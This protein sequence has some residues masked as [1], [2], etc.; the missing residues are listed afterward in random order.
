MHLILPL[1]II[2]LLGI[3]LV[4]LFLLFFPYFIFETIKFEKAKK[5]VGLRSPFKFDSYTQHGVNQFVEECR[6]KSI[7]VET[8]HRTPNLCHFIRLL[9]EKGLHLELVKDG[10]EEYN[11][12]LGFEEWIEKWRRIIFS[13]T[14]TSADFCKCIKLIMKAHHFTEFSNATQP[15]DG[16]PSGKIKEDD[17]FFIFRALYIMHYNIRIKKNNKN[18][19]V[20][21]DAASLCERSNESKLVDNSEE[22][23]YKILKLSDIVNIHQGIDISE[24]DISFNEKDTGIV[25][26][27]DIYKNRCEHYC[28]SRS[29][30][31]SSCMVN[32]GDLIMGVSNPYHIAKWRGKDS[33]L[34][35][36]CLSFHITDE[37]VNSD[38]LLLYLRLVLEEIKTEKVLKEKLNFDEIINILIVIPPYRMQRKIINESRDLKNDF[39]QIKIML[40]NLDKQFIDTINKNVLLIS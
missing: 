38:F 34:A 36:K 11:T 25:Y 32:L 26:M 16:I 9:D 5:K 21:F 3:L 22:Q 10:H 23:K 2:V 18:V 14:I 30:F 17:S 24:K 33:I 1:L 39:E 8:S 29:S 27:N 28:S 31:F 12:F 13:S 6:M 40:F 7:S 15:N 37:S 35:K 19:C 4:I 20:I